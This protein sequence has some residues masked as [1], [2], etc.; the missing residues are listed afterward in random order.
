MKETLR[1]QLVCFCMFGLVVAPLGAP[2]AQSER[3]A[4]VLEEVLVTAQKR[5]ESL[6]DAPISL[7]VFDQAAL[8]NIGVSEFGSI[9]EYTPN[10]SI[11]KQ[12]A[13]QDNYGM[14][15]RGVVEGET[16]LLVDPRVGIYI[17]GIYLGR[18]TGLA[19]DINDLERIEVLRGPQGTLYGRNTIG[20]ALNIV[21]ARP[22]GEF[23]FKQK[24]STGQ[25]GLFESRTSVNLPSYSPLL[26]LVGDLLASFTY[27][28]KEHDG[29]IR[30]SA[31]NR[32]LGEAETEALRVALRWEYSDEIS[33]DYR[34]EQSEREDYPD[35]TQISYVRGNHRQFG[36]PII[37]AAAA[38]ADPDR[39]SVISKYIGRSSANEGSYS[40]IEGHSLIV[41]MDTRWGEFKSISG[42]REWDSGTDTTDFGSWLF[43]GS[44]LESIW[45]LNHP[46][47]I[48]PGGSRYVR[49]SEFID[50]AEVG[51]RLGGSQLRYI[52]DNKL[53]ASVF[54]ARRD[55]EQEQFS[56]EFQLVGSF[57]D[58]LEYTVGAFYFEEESAEVN[59]QWYS[60]PIA[61]ITYPNSKLFLPADFRGG[62]NPA[63]RVS[64]DLIFAGLGGSALTSVF[65]NEGELVVPA[66]PAGTTYRQ[67][68]YIGQEYFAYGQ[69]VTAQG[70]Y[71]QVRYQISANLRG[72]F[73]LRYTEEE[74]KAYVENTP[75]P[76]KDFDP[77]DPKRETLDPDLKLLLGECREN[78]LPLPD[79]ATDVAM[80]RERLCSRAEGE[81]KW[82]NLSGFLNFNYNFSEL[83]S[84]YLTLSNGYTS[85]GFNARSSLTEASKPFD[86]ETLI[87]YEIGWKYQSEDNRVRFNGAVFA[88]EY[89]DR[90]LPQ[91]E[92]GAAGASV[93]ISN[94]GEQL[95]R[96][97]EFEL[98]RIFSEGL[99]VT[100]S[101]A[102]LDVE[103]KKF[104]I[105]LID[106]D[107]GEALRDEN[108]NDVTVDIS[109]S[110]SYGIVAPFAPQHTASVQLQYDFE[111][112]PI[113]DLSLW[114]G[115]SYS[116]E[117]VYH[118]QLN[119]HDSTGEYALI[120][121]RLTL[122][123]NAGDSLPG[124]LRAAFWGKNIRD[125]EVRG[126]GT[127]FGPLGFVVNPYQDVGSFGFDLVYDY[128]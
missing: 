60:L 32:L 125:K 119:A 95:Q 59:P 108:G 78:I 71:G 122:D 21:T 7:S 94:V 43:S 45:V 12:L 114:I 23:S 88:M 121:F 26:G 46:S 30:N 53:P 6:Q 17:D 15:I 93:Q 79:P 74:K 90:Q 28:T 97:A 124:D 67:D 82:D 10:L 8:E 13:S 84:G 20:G 76:A 2:L 42:L 44:D 92:A 41:T 5:E 77:A 9:A 25:D 70:L 118:P 27:L 91:F 127:D 80:V 38:A 57:S 55:S 14:G 106:R 4:A 107:T 83:M 73:G 11:R 47:A 116:T 24:I 69:D 117:L 87:N 120:D 101:Y 64:E 66:D 34:Y 48:A 123:V 85:G 72:T 68:L 65:N 62:T 49:L 51:D 22:G 99:R 50:V 75:N 111:P 105:G 39:R 61:L 33:I 63:A 110:E 29:L 16:S 98:T 89:E 36:G 112:L 37:Q 52:G 104:V 40:D 18:S 86:E 115:A 102:Y 126:W 19:F 100:L 58:D 35:F 31:D 1:R 103:F 56:Q 81:E 109:K 54:N 3:R 96:G 113:G 128:Y